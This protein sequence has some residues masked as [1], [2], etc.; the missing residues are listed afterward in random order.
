MLMEPLPAWPGAPTFTNEKRSLEIACQAACKHIES[1]RGTIYLKH[2]S[3]RT[4]R[5][6]RMNQIPILSWGSCRR[7]ALAAKLPMRLRV[8]IPEGG[9]PLMDIRWGMLPSW[10]S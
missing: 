6:W 5:S 4:L 10:G 1:E 9:L 8:N 2:P 7:K 3:V